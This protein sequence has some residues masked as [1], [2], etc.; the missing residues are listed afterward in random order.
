MSKNPF[1][2]AVSASAYIV[3]VVLVMTLGV[4][5]ASSK[6]DTILAPMAAVSVF[7]LFAAVMGYLFVYQPAQLYFDGKKKQAIDLFLKTVA[8]FAGITVIILVLA[9]SG[10]FS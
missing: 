9:F 7:T 1:I 4:K 2:N 6:P 10:I 5:V 8:V 3:L